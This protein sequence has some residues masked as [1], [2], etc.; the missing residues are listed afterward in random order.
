MRAALTAFLWSQGLAEAA[1]DEWSQL[2][3]SGGRVGMEK[4]QDIER[5]NSVPSIALLPLVAFG[6]LA[7][8]VSGQDK[9]PVCPWTPSSRPQRRALTCEG[10]RHTGYGHG[11]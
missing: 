2:C 8:A 6:K 3:Q 10:H 9:V 5:E 4:M 11:R 7:N 1:E